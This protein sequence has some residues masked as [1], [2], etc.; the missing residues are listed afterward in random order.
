VEAVG[1]FVIHYP[2]YILFVALA[3]RI[4]L[5][6]HVYAA[7]N[8]AYVGRSLLAVSSKLGRRGGPPNGD[9]RP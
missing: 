9:R 4:D 6:L 2:S 3:N 5:F 8:A 7:I 1:R